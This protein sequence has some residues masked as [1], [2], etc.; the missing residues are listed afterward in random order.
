MKS[1]ISGL[2]MQLPVDKPVIVILGPTAVGKTSL[3]VELARE[4][5]A[6]IVSLD[7]RYLYKGM[8]IGTAK[9]TESEMKG[10][11]HHL[12]DV[13]EPDE[14]ISL[15]QIQMEAYQ[16]IDKILENHK[17]PMLVGGTG[18]Y[19]WSVVEGWL[20]PKIKPDSNFRVVLEKYANEIGAQR[21]YEY[22]KLLDPQAASRIEPNNLR[23]SIRALEVIFTTGELFSKQKSKIPP[24]YDFKLIG[25]QRPR[26]SL[27]QRVDQRI[28][29]MLEKG[30]I[31]ETQ[32]LIKQGYDRNLPSMSAIGY[33]EIINYLEGNISLEE[34]VV[35]IKRRTRNFI[36]H[37]ANWFKKDD[38]RIRWYEMNPDVLYA[39]SSYIKIDEGWII[40]KSM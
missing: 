14:T 5:N 6:E 20:P 18:Q 12:I 16:Y 27:Y 4:L 37:Q 9:P 15:P 35:L 17:I 30:L 34:A 39:I 40:G 36:R 38:V 32:E 8:S 28:D 26:E 10:I 29:R 3:S 2:K 33:K 21:I 13:V 31:Q 22:V 24:P 1:S 25:L 11:P 7:S 19:V 23:R